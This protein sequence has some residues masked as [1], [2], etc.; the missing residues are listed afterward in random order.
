LQI[1]PHN[2]EVNWAPLSEVKCAG[3]PKRNTHVVKKALAQSIAEIEAKGTT[4]THLV[5]LSIMVKR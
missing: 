1:F 5:A 3:T 4:S 2:A